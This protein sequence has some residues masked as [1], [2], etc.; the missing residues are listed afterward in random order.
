VEYEFTESGKELVDDA[1]TDPLPRIQ[2]RAIR[3]VF[4]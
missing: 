2:Q 4:L 3:N 1:T